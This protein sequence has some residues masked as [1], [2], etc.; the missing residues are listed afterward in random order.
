MLL[1]LPDIPE[2]EAVRIFVEFERMESAIKGKSI[3][4][5]VTIVLTLLPVIATKE[6]KKEREETI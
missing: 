5:V 3:V 4:C 6:K 1:Q 2:E